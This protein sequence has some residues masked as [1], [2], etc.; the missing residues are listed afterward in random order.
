MDD[1]LVL[2]VFN[3]CVNVK[4]FLSYLVGLEG[5]LGEEFV[6]NVE[7]DRVLSHLYREYPAMENRIRLAGGIV[8]F[9]G[10]M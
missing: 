2:V 6:R 1:Y 9:I 7:F 8:N 5:R 10:L 3:Y 4:G